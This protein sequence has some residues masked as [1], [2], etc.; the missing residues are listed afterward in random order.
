MSM[1]LEEIREECYETVGE[2]LAQLLEP[3]MVD[4]WF[5]RG[6]ERLGPRYEQTGT[7]TW[8]SGDT[9]VTLPTGY[10]RLSYIVYSDSADL[11]WYKVFN[12]KFV[13]LVSDGF[14]SDGTAEIGYW[15]YYP[16]V[17]D[18]D[19]SVMEPQEDEACIQY[20][21]YR[22][23][24]MLASSRANY[25]RFVTT[26]GQNGVTTDDLLEIANEHLAAFGD[27]L[28]TVPLSEPIT[29]YND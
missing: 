3:A 23:F 7:I 11:G 24:R 18:D 26:T 10:I 21:C 19:D 20:T 13:S 17:T 8:D 29:F 28:N 12:K 4:R 9:E 1:S 2:Q 15:T 16:A 27:A 25:R 5:N 22:F 6:R 14:P